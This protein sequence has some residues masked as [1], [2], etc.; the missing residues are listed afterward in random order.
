MA[1]KIDLPKNW[2][3]TLPYLRTPTYSKLLSPAQLSILRTQPPNAPAIPVNAP[4]GPCSS[5]KITPISDPLHPANG[6]SG[7]FATRDLA[8]GTFVLC[9][10][11]E[12]HGSSSLEEK[13]RYGESDYDL[14]IDRDGD[15]AV[16]ASRMGNEARFFNDYRGVPG[17]TKPNVEFKECWD[18]RANRGE[19]CMGVWVLKEGK[20]KKFKGIK[21]GEEILVSYGRGFWGARRGEESW[22]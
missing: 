5:V 3:P 8:P 9:Y 11:G 19:R 22:E 10:M 1:P 16:D 15:I 18:G 17:K 2:P 7:L 21:K 14:S 6:Q 12:L 13:E 4:L 20:N